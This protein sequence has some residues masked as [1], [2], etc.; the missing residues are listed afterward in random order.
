MDGYF[1]KIF[2]ASTIFTKLDL[3]RFSSSLY[4]IIYNLIFF[5]P[6]SLLG[7]MNREEIFCF[8]D[9]FIRDSKKLLT[10]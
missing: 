2:S 8:T 6:L 1:F 5:Q 7:S 4:T 3:K 10:I 9:F